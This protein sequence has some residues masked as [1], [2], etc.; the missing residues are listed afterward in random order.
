MASL[1]RG[2]GRLPDAA[3][4]HGPLL[5]A[6][7][8]QPGESVPLSALTEAKSQ[9]GPEF[10]MHYNEYRC[11]QINGRA[12]PGYSS[13]QANK[14]LEEVFA[15]TMPQRD[16]I[17]IIWACPFRNRRR[18]RACRAV[19]IFGLFRWCVCSSSWRRS[20]ESWSL[21]FSV[22]ICWG[23]RSRSSAHFSALFVRGFAEQCVRANRFDHVDRPG[24]Q[25]CDS[26]RRVCQD[27]I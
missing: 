17:L 4:G 27:G 14:A 11:A 18:R 6:G 5:R 25:K 2:R 20:F 16:G 12:A 15:Q 3:G 1:S 26:N 8:N 23:R 19:L 9:V 13:D 7:T 24:R 22:L 21:P 10:V